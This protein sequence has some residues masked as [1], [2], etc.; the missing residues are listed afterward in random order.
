MKSHRTESKKTPTSK[1]KPQTKPKGIGMPVRQES[2]LITSSSPQQS[3][4]K[5]MCDDLFDVPLP[6]KEIV[7]M[8]L[9]RG[10]NEVEKSLKEI[11]F[12]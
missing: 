7:E 9:E 1:P 6:F 4:A 3:G 11:H 10:E 2:D 5:E 12:R 8:G